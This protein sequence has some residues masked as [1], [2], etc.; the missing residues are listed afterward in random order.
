M[1]MKT[2]RIRD[3]CPILVRRTARA[4]RKETRGVRGRHAQPQFA[5]RGL[6]FFDADQPR[7]VLIVTALIAK[8]PSA[9]STRSTLVLIESASV[10]GFVDFAETSLFDLGLIKPH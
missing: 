8:K 2:W 7:T 6:P 4:T 1:G 10:R 9:G 5:S 3:L